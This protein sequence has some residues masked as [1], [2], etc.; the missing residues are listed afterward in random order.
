MAQE[1][2]YLCLDI[3]QTFKPKQLLQ[4]VQHFGGRHDL[5]I[6]KQQMTQIIGIRYLKK[7]NTI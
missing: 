3:D 1:L 5:R 7:S 2:T 6:C 4:S